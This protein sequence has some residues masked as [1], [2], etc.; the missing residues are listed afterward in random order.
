MKSTKYMVA[1]FLL[2]L[3]I[4]LPAYADSGATRFSIPFNFYVGENVLVAGDYSVATVTERTLR[5]AS[6][7]GKTSLMILVNPVED[8]L[9]SGRAQIV[10]HR[11]GDTYFCA[12]V[13]APSRSEGHELFATGL[14]LRLARELKQTT[15]MI[16][17]SK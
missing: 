8:P 13:W 2:A 11:Y 10:F 12:R 16:L 7:D 4:A 14:E 15:V 9:A 3:A 1:A 5:L 6:A 17:A